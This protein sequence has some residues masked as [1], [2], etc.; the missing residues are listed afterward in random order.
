MGQPRYRARVASPWVFP[1]FVWAAQV[2]NIKSAGLAVRASL[3]EAAPRSTA[4][5]IVIL[6]FVPSSA[7]EGRPWIDSF[8]A[9]RTVPTASCSILAP[10]LFW[11][12]LARP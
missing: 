11:L 5:R 6:M 3:R 12:G 10:L 4:L 9:E 1:T 2:L 7:A 8:Y